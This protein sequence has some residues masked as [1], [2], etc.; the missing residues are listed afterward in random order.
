MD[1]ELVLGAKFLN[2]F[3]NFIKILIPFLAYRDFVNNAKLVTWRSAGKGTK[4][5]TQRKLGK[6][7]MLDICGVEKDAVCMMHFIAKKNLRIA[8]NGGKEISKGLR[9]RFLEGNTGF[10]LRTITLSLNPRMEFV[11][12]AVDRAIKSRLWLSIIV[13]KVEKFV[14]FSVGLATRGLDHL[15]RAQN[16]YARPS[17]IWSL[18]SNYA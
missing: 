4:K 6:M 17:P 14:R 15:T 9:I 1:S 10:L 11:E 13:I 2:Q 3:L 5:K 18:T 12:F 16:F 7:I 8:R